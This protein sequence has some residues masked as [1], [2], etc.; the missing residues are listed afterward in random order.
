MSCVGSEAVLS[1]LHL[2]AVTCSSPITSP[3]RTFSLK[4]TIF[5]KNKNVTNM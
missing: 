5:K 2:T 4:K 1:L 3:V